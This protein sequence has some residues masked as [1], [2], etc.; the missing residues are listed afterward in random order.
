MNMKIALIDNDY[1]V[2]VKTDFD[3]KEKNESF[4]KF[5]QQIK[6]EL[7]PGQRAYLVIKDSGTDPITFEISHLDCH[8]F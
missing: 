4:R 8:L 7:F 2:R 3:P 6:E 1:F 5:F